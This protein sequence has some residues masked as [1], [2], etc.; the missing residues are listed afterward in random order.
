MTYE[1]VELDF[2]DE[3]VHKHIDYIVSTLSPESASLVPRSHVFSTD[4]RLLGLGKAVLNE[5]FVDAIKAAV[6]RWGA[7]DLTDEEK[8]TLKERAEHGVIS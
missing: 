1:T 5:H 3:E 4:E 8:E 6:E 2:T 7:V